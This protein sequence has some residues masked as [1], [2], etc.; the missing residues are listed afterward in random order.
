MQPVR[1]LPQWQDTVRQLMLF[2]S[3]FIREAHA[4]RPS[5]TRV[6]SSPDELLAVGQLHRCSDRA[7]IRTAT[8]GQ[9]PLRQTTLF[10]QQRQQGKLTRRKAE[11]CQVHLGSTMRR[12]LRYPQPHAKRVLKIHFSLFAKHYPYTDYHLNTGHSAKVSAIT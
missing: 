11:L 1:R 2:C 7:G 4:K 8:F 10:G 5:G 9:L 12:Q 6:A 3:P